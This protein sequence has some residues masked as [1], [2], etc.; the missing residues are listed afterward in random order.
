MEINWQDIFYF[1][2][3]LAM[4]ITLIICIWLMR[5]FFIA[6]KLI[7]NLTA[8]AHKWS[9]IVNDIR[10]FKKG[11]KLKVLRFLLKIIDKGGQNE[12]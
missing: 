9:N 4:I 5:L 6:S 11:M 2:A 10:Y 3:S 12:Q 1:T 8:T 7:R